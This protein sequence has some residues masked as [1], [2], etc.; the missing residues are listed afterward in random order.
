MTREARAIGIGQVEI[1]HRADE[2]LPARRA[3]EAGQG[4][5]SAGGVARRDL[6]ERGEVRMRRIERPAQGRQRIERQPAPEHVG[7]RPQDGPVLAR[8]ARRE[9]GAV[10]HLHAPFRVD[11]G[12]GLLRVGGAGQDHVGPLRA[13]V[14][15]RALVDR[16]KARP[17]CRSRR[18]RDCRARRPRHDGPCRRRRGRPPPARSR[19]RARRPAPPPCAARRSRSSPRAA[20]PNV[21]AACAARA[22]IARPSGR[23]S[24]PAPTMTSGRCAAR[25]FSAKP[26]R[27]ATR[28]AS[29]SGPAPR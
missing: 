2:G 21:W 17:R 14:A 23:A 10:G 13:A 22:T 3:A 28:S 29:V 24:A 1:L 19:D 25:N 20:A 6:V 27:P 4:A 16:R 8:V 5:H 11:V 15:M 9:R 7:E 18:R 26:C 12:A